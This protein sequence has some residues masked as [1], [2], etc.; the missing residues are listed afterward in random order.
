MVQIELYRGW[1]QKALRISPPPYSRN[2]N[3]VRAWS[4]M[5]H[6]QKSHS[7]NSKENFTFT[8]KSGTL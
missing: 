2:P 5:P 8:V 7:G 1:V 4:G 6:T 3:S